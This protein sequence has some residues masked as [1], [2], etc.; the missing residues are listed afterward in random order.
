[1]STNTG[2]SGDMIQSPISLPAPLS[3][4][5]PVQRKK[6]K[7]G[8]KKPAS[9]T[10]R[11]NK[12]ADEMPGTPVTGESEAPLLVDLNSRFANIVS[13]N[14][15]VV[16]ERNRLNDQ[17]NQQEENHKDELAKIKA[18]YEQ[19]V[20][21]GIKL[22]NNASNDAFKLRQDLENA[23][24]K[25]NEA[26]RKYEEK[27]LSE[28]TAR[29][30]AEELQ[31]EVDD[32]RAEQTQ[33]RRKHQDLDAQ[34]MSLNAQLTEARSDADK[35]R[36]QLDEEKIKLNQKNNELQSLHEKF[37]TALTVKNVEVEEARKNQSTMLQQSLNMKNSHEE[38]MSIAIEN[39][40]DE[41]EA[42]VKRLKKKF[43]ADNKRALDNLEKKLK[44]SQD[45][46]LAKRDEA[47]KNRALMEQATSG[48]AK[49]EQD[50]AR[51]KATNMSLEADL[52]SKDSLAKEEIC[53]LKAKLADA[54]EKNIKLEKT[55]KEKKETYLSM[56]K[57][58]MTYRQLLEVEE[59]RLN[60]TPSPIRRKRAR[61]DTRLSDCNTP[62]Q[63]KSRSAENTLQEVDVSE[64]GATENA[65]PDA[66]C[67]IM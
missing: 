3:G 36:K 55:F 40:R 24:E 19:E 30:L 59:A 12:M 17:L 11:T 51:L 62:V 49:L 6:A 29:Q 9:S 7:K 5:T 53:D 34:K 48:K 66:S 46:L 61:A 67:F 43:Q 64:I 58:C 13:R 41:H 2:S 38:T 54:D 47:A 52:A 44:N 65:R 15:S 25:K 60:I 14:A 63:K 23:N 42:E 35:F 18:F 27:N 45:A 1:M 50:L 37:E 28:R 31:K 26:A 10:K 8:E 16:E 4:S 57:E 33:L 21:E 20:Q 22:L 56:Q 39:I 32:M